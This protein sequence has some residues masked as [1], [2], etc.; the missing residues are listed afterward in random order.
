MADVNDDVNDV[1]RALSA[2]ANDWANHGGGYVVCGAKETKD[3]HGFAKLVA[4]GLTA[5]RIKEVTGRVIQGCRERVSPSIAPLVDEL[6]ADTP[7]RRVLVFTMVATSS[8]HLFRSGDDTG[9]HYIRVGAETREA[10][11]GLLLQ[12][13][14][15]K[16]AMEPWDRRPCKEATVSDIDLLVLRDAL[17]RMGIYQQD[18]RVEDYVSHERSLHALV[19]PLRAG[20][21][22]RRLASAQLC[23]APIR[24]AHA[25]PC[26]RGI[27]NFL[28]LSRHGPLHAHGRT[29]RTHQ[30]VARAG[31][32]P[33]RVAQ[34]A[35]LQGLRQSGPEERQRPQVPAGGAARSGRECARSS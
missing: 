21:A 35:D 15:R 33:H 20:A 4:T 3:E 25:V 23:S 12:L 5:K 24:P 34:W 1:I 28:H 2:F 29:P 13:L 10:R 30:H 19:P 7:D 32:A 9:R 16:G 31:A 27:F 22:N 6:P 17:Q 14:V 11:N 8:A 26:A 18:M